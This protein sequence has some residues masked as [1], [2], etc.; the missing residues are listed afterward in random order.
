MLAKNKQKINK[1]RSISASEFIALKA[2]RIKDM[3]E[4]NFTRVCTLDGDYYLIIDYYAQI[5][6]QPLL[7]IMQID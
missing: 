7:L 3:A 4:L 1:K 6:D 2:N 5:K